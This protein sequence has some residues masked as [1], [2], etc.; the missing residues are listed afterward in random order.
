M[1]PAHKIRIIVA[2][3]PVDFRKGHDGLAA[4]VQSALKADPFTGT[5]F[6]FRAKR[7]DRLKILF[8]D[9][10]GLVMTYKRL[11]ETPFTWPAIRDG[12]IRLNRAQF[13]ALFA[14]LDW[15][16]VT[17]PAVSRPAAAE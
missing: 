1:L 17:A 7:A 2:T 12:V 16:R 6:V 9:G 14:G 15:R 3:Q 4:L 5:V 8:W 11:E 10:T 13:E